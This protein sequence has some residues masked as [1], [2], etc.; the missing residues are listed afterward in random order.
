M[1]DEVAALPLRTVLA[2]LLIVGLSEVDSAACRALVTGGAPIGGVFLTA[3]D[4]RQLTRPALV[5]IRGARLPVTVAV[6]DE[7]GRVQVSGA[8]SRLPSARTMAATLTPAQVRRV[9]GRRGRVLAAHGVTM[10][11]GPD[12]DVSRQPNRAVIG[13]RSFGA[14]ADTVQRYATAYAQGLSD[15][16]VRSV[17]KHFPGHGRAVGDSHR[18]LPVT[19]SVTDLAGTDWVAF[20]EVTARTSA[21]VMM[22]HLRVPGL[23]SS[24][25]PSSVDPAVYAALRTRVGYRGVVVTDELAAMRGVSSRFPL[26]ESVRRS[27]AAGADVA[28]FNAGRNEV[29]LVGQ[30]LNAL[31]R[32]VAD[33]TLPSRQ[34]REAATRVLALKRV[35]RP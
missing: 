35:G 30:V 20:R 26:A 34:V 8:G 12:A 23:S 27:L 16:G 15:A 14:T 11:F 6:D 32:A 7:G 19:P 10:V 24:G 29:Q 31:E 28:L 33:G 21:A 13:D 9:A 5:A 25:L 18:V 4:L 22:G 1:S 17:I 3:R 2:Q